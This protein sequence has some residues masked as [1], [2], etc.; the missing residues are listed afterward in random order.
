VIPDIETVVEVRSTWQRAATSPWAGFEMRY[1]ARLADG[2]EVALDGC[3]VE[4]LLTALRS[5]GAQLAESVEGWSRVMRVV[6]AEAATTPRP[7]TVEEAIEQMAARGKANRPKLAG[8]L[9]SAAELVKEGRV[10]LDGDAAKVG[11]YTITADACNCADFAHRGGWCKHR[12]AVRMARHL[13]ASGFELPAPVEVGP[14]PIVSEANRRLIESGAVVD[15]EQRSRQA[16]AQSG[17][18]ARR[19][20]LT[21]MSQGARTL[22]ARIAWQAGIAPRSDE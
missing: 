21:A 18:A 11:P 5:A 7:G 20:A 16:Y 9:D 8:R 10:V 1:T 13:A 12:L 19:W 14:R 2:R 15:A 4:A 6:G 3:G 22:P 17:E